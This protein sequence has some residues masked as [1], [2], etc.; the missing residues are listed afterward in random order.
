MKWIQNVVKSVYDPA[1]YRDIVSGKET[2][3]FA[4]F[5]ILMVAF[6]ILTA[7]PSYISFSSWIS[8]PDG[9]S[10]FRDS[11]TN[12]YPDGLVLQY[13]DGH[14]TSNVEEPYK[15]PMPG[16]LGGS[17]SDANGK[18]A[19]NLLVIDTTHTIVPEDFVKYDTAAILGNT[20]LWTNDPQKGIQ[21]NT[22]EKW[23]KDPFTFDKG[24]V[25]GFTDT[26]AGYLKPI[27]I[28]GVVLLPLFLVFSLSIGYLLYLLFGAL[29][30]LIVGK[31]RTVELSYGQSYHVALHLITVPV[32]YGLVTV[33][34][35]ILDVR[36][37]FSAILVIFAIINLVPVKAVPAEAKAE[38]SSES[39]ID[40]I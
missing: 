29:L 39:I 26:V 11:I 19:E 27:L 22:F 35:P 28:V 3:S 4:Y 6:S 14:V 15:I 2:G 8:R 10:S 1:Y 37:V 13:G 5:F 18:T 17:S 7:I 34:F 32:F 38:D 25:T 20:A 31:I 40:G 33:I 24:L 36:F 23:N 21:V 16:A 30:V 12:L 9:F